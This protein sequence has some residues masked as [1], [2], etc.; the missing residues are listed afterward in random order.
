MQ[1]QIAFSHNNLVSTSGLTVW[2]DSG[3]KIGFI[4]K[5]DAFDL[6]CIVFFREA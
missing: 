3:D 1:S 2:N 4:G 6:V 5:S